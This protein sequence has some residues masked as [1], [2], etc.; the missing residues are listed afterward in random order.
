MTVEE[1]EEIFG[2]RWNYWSRDEQREFV[3]AL[4]PNDRHQAGNMLC[5]RLLAENPDCNPQMFTQIMFGLES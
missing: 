4:D 2:K 1:G 3:R 5:L